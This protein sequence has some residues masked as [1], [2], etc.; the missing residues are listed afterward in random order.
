MVPIQL[1]ID[2]YVFN[3]PQVRTWQSMVIELTIHKFVVSCPQACIYV[4]ICSYLAAHTFVFICPQFQILLSRGTYLALHR[5][6]F[7]YLLAVYNS[8]VIY[9]RSLVSCPYVLVWLSICPQ[10]VVN[11]HVFNYPFSRNQVF[12]GPYSDVVIWLVIFPQISN[13]L[14]I[15]PYY[16]S[17]FI[18]KYSSIFSCNQV[19]GFFKVFSYVNYLQVRICCHPQVRSQLPTVHQLAVPMPFCQWGGWGVGGHFPKKFTYPPSKKSTFPPS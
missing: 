19:N 5:S 18:F 3:C 2:W 10:L 14:F 16:I 4:F 8:V 6:A 17:I 7:M 15:C 13:Q 1:S 9:P 11:M 12:I